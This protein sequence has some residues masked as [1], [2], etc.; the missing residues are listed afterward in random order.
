MCQTVFQQPARPAKYRIESDSAEAAP[1]GKTRGR[2]W[3]A[4]SNRI[5]IGQILSQQVRRD[6]DARD[7]YEWS[8]VNPYLIFVVFEQDASI[9][10]RSGVA[11]KNQRPVSERQEE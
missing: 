5:S 2:N 10:D 11:N 4:A 8:E 3:K 1:S 9:H 7:Q 6:R